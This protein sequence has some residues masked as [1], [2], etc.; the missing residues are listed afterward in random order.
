MLPH[1]HVVHLAIALIACVIIGTP[2]DTLPSSVISNSIERIVN[3]EVKYD[4]FSGAIL[5]AKEG[6]VTYGALEGCVALTI[7]ESLAPTTVFK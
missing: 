6:E 2:S 3:E 4:L 1:S 7:D 5:V